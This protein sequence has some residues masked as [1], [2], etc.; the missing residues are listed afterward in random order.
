MSTSILIAGG[1]TKPVYKALSGTSSTD[2]YV[3]T[4]KQERVVLSQIVN[5]SGGAIVVTL[6]YQDTVLATD[7]PY[8]TRSIPSNDTVLVE[9]PVRLLQA[10]KIKVVGNTGITIVLAVLI[11]NGP[12]GGLFGG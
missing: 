3:A 4:Q 7:V 9:F 11:D 1:L 12:L 8:F 6:T 2:V 10:D 5:T